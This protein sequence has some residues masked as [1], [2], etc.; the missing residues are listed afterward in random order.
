MCSGV[1]VVWGIT[2]IEPRAR[3]SVF[4]RVGGRGRE[5]GLWG[6]YGSRGLYENVAYDKG[7]TDMSL[8]GRYMCECVL[9]NRNVCPVVPLRSLKNNVL[10]SSCVR[11]QFQGLRMTR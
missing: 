9:F 6:N 5:G 8:W 4:G 11:L 10:R 2:P 3:V 1:P 7:L